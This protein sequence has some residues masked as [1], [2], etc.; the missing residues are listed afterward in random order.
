MSNN[1]PL[2]LQPFKQKAWKPITQEQD[3]SVLDSKFSGVP[4][5]IQNEEYPKC[6]NCQQPMQLFIQLNLSRLPEPLL[7]KFGHGLLQMFYCINQ[8]PLCEVDCEAFFPFA[9]SVLI[10]I[11]EPEDN[12]PTRQTSPEN[13]FP[14]KLIT[15]WQELEDY[16][17]SEE[18]ES[19]GIELTGEEWDEWFE[20]DFPQAGDKLGGYPHWI[21]GI[22]YPDCPICRDKMGLVFQ[23]DSEDN[24]PFMFGDLGCGYLTQCRNH[25]DQLAFGWACS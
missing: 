21:Q 23:I 3:G 14:P 20:S 17:N 4:Y 22:E 7:E 15:G 2:T 8:T 25:Q 10:R 5:L 13:S 11:I 12:F 24:L 19:L 16:P 18:G 1:I 9:K 6:Q